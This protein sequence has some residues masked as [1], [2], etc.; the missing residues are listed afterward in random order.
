MSGWR[1]THWW[2]ATCFGTPIGPWRDRLG[3]VFEDLEADGLGCADETGTF[4]VTVP[5]G[6]ERRSAWQ[7]SEEEDHPEPVTWPMRAISR[8]RR[9]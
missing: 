2:R 6:Y 3:E 9:R 8:G 7:E 5:G 1:M 4:Y